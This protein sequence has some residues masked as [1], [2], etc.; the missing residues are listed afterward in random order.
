[1]T[2]SSLVISTLCEKDRPLWKRFV[3]ESQNGTLFHDLDFLAYH[4]SSRF[5]SVQL[6]FRDKGNLCA[7]FPAVEVKQGGQRKTLSSHPGASHGG[8]AIAKGLGAEEVYGLVSKLV[9]WAKEEG[10]GRIEMTLPPG[11]YAADPNQHLDFALYLAGFRILRRQLSGV[12]PLL[13]PYPQITNSALRMATKARR[14]G[15]EVR[16]SRSDER[17]YRAFYDILVENR[18]KHGAAPTHT[19]EEM[20]RLRRLIPDQLVLFTAEFNGQP[21]AGALLFVLNE[22]VVL[23]FY[24]AHRWEYQEY[25]ATNLLFHETIQWAKAKGF[26]Y[27]DMGTSM[28]G[29]EPHW[30]LVDFKERFGA[31]GFLKDTFELELT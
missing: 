13:P 18:A 23:N 25:R 31:R 28:L 5:R 30:S 17:D 19:W 2:S 14:S 6:L 27:L 11:I 3:Y 9:N 24:L 29:E 12:V 22:R 15:V 20:D 1:M 21:I 8:L 26:R 7:I 4:P 10:Y 16:E